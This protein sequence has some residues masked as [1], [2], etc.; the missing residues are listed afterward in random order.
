M[1]TTEIGLTYA[2]VKYAESGLIV[3][4][5]LTPKI[6]T[7]LTKNLGLDFALPIGFEQFAFAGTLGLPYRARLGDNTVLQL[8]DRIYSFR[9]YSRVPD[10]KW[11]EEIETS[12]GIFRLNARLEQQVSNAFSLVLETGPQAGG[13]PAGFNTASISTKRHLQPQSWH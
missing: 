2:A 10:E 7:W 9:F 5:T 12:T 1:N 3:G 6:R 13:L 8:F 4:K 11:A